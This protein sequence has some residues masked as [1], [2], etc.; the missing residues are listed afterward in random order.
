[1]VFKLSHE[2]WTGIQDLNTRNDFKFGLVIS[3][4]AGNI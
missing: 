3:K 2:N 1:M 4:I